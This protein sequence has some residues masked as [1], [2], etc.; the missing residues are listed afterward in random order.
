VADLLTDPLTAVQMAEHIWKNEG[1]MNELYGQYM[2]LRHHMGEP[3]Y[4][5]S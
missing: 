3:Q 5:I 2:R 4:L 1:E